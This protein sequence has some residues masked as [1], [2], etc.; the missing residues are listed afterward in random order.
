M[1]SCVFTCIY[2]SVRFANLS[3]EMQNR[4]DKKEKQTFILIF[5]L[6]YTL[7]CNL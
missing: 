5:M 3:T 2:V 1:L 4:N 6:P 7:D